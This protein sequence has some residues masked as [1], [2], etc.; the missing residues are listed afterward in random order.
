MVG[1][2]F[3]AEAALARRYRMLGNAQRRELNEKDAHSSRMGGG[4]ER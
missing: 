1:D 2:L 3:G 4:F